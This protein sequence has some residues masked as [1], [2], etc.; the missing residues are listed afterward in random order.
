M[1]E[2]N[3]KAEKVTILYEDNHLIAIN[4]PWGALSQGDNTGDITMIDVVKDYIKHQ[5][6]K[7]GDVYLGL[8]HRLDRPTSGVLLFARTSK[9]LVRLNK[10]MQEKRDMKK[11]YWA[12]VDKVPQDLEGELVHYVKK[13]GKTN[14]SRAYDKQVKNSKLARLKY[15]FIGRT[16]HYF[17]LEIELLTGRHH[18]IRAQLAQL[19]IHIKG[20]LKYGFPRSNKDG[21]GI[22]LHARRLELLHPVKKEWI[23]IEAPTPNE[24]LWREFETMTS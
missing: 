20:D 1:K 9:A 4:K 2:N 22:H 19:G 16:D 6:N 21:N 7:P 24:N 5:Y 18:Q 15:K 3:T 10:M 17:L 14:K 13:D 12:V 23:V 8:V 11:I